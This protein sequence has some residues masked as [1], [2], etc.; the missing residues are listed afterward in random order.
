VSEPPRPT[1]VIPASGASSLPRLPAYVEHGGEIACRHPADALGSRMYGFVIPARRDRLG[2]Y[3]DRCFNKPTRGEEQWRAVSDQVLLNFVDIPTMGSTD[4][5]DEKLGVT[6]ER[7]AA[8]WFPVYEPRRNRLAW[9]IP[10]MF[11]DSG[12]ALAGGRE[13][14]GFPKQLGRLN[15]PVGDSAP[16]KLT[17]NTVTFET[18]G[19]ASQARDHRVVTVERPGAPVDLASEGSEAAYALDTVIKAIGAVVERRLVTGDVR[20][21]L[22]DLFRDGTHYLH[23]VLPHVLFLRDLVE[24]HAPMLLLKQFRDA[25]VPGAACYQALVHVDMQVLQFRG[26]GLLPEDYQV[27]IKPLE[28]EPIS[29]ELGV[30]EA[31]VPSMA[32]WLDFDF[33]VKLG[34]ILWEAPVG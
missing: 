6:H 28:G 11:V 18:Y 1:L 30:A 15:I 17:L 13:V 8:I 24:E 5:E 23:D 26:G 25:H 33:L 27:T 32:F 10:Y 19:P 16:P 34:E 4:E 3:C 14:Y 7:E 21:W 29:R 9:A 22:K 12:L 2:A 20:G 31:S